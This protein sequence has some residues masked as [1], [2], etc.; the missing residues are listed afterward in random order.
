MSAKEQPMS[1]HH[2]PIVIPMEDPILHTA[3]SPFCR[4]E[5]CPC[6]EDQE[7]LESLSR[8]V[9]D[10]VLTPAEATTIALGKTI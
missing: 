9:Q 5:T 1:Q 7:L 6:H 3:D 10:G 2:E 4:D 8:Q